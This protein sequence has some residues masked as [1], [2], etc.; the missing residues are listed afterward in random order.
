MKDHFSNGGAF[1]VTEA[2]IMRKGFKSRQFGFVGFK[3]V[4]HAQKA[5]KHFN[6]TYIDTSKMEV[7][8]AR[9]QGDEHI[10]RAGTWHTPGSSAY[11]ITHKDELE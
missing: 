5:Q 10:P 6:K 9:R 4:K 8:F 3:D 11:A 2:K 7:D 1:E